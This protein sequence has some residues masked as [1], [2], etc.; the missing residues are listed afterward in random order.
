M[1]KTIYE[2]IFSFRIY[3][4]VMD[5]KSVYILDRKH[6]N[7]IE[8]GDMPLGVFADWIKRVEKEPTRFD[9]WVEKEEKENA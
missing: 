3:D 7:V 5:G 4:A 2:S 8:A 6:R 9:F 1:P